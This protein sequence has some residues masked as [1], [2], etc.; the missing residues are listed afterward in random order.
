[1]TV[2]GPALGVLELESIARGLKVADALVKRAQVRLAVAEPVTPGKFLLLFTGEVAEVEES[3]AAA[4]AEA[5][6]LVLDTLLLTQIH[7]QVV[8]ALEGRPLARR[9][10]EALGVVELHTVAATVKSA[11]VALKRAQVRLNHLH[12]ARGIG[13]KGWFTLS[14]ELH[15]VEAALEGAAA[16]V[17]AN[18]LVN[19]EVIARPH[20]DL[21]W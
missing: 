11:D 18:L 8:H 2:T 12:L 14:G 1:M 13:G 5:Q 15:D 9:P 17:G 19:T 6:P 16:S 7:P 3:Y 10:G 20:G 21:P 4:L